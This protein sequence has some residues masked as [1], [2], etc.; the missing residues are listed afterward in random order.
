MSNSKQPKKDKNIAQTVENLII[1]TIEDMGLILW[2]VEFKKEG[3]DWNLTIFIDKEHSVTLNDCENVSRA[4]DPILDEN[5]PIEQSYYLQVFSPGLGRKL[6]KPAHFE[7]YLGMNI[8]VK[9]IRPIENERE[10][11]GTL[12]SFDKQNITVNTNQGILTFVIKET[13][14]IKVDD[15]RDF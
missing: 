4:V 5:D 8:F 12:E 2:D 1:K 10:F 7:K 9:T 15:D 11:F 3:I 14:Y 13:A 6:T